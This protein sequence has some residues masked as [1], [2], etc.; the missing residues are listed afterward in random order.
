M[1]WNV[2]GVRWNGY[3]NAAIQTASE[4]GKDKARK[5]SIPDEKKDSEKRIKKSAHLLIE[6]LKNVR[7]DAGYMSLSVGNRE[8]IEKTLDDIEPAAPEVD[9][10]QQKLTTTT[11]DT[12]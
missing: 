10:N 7:H 1:I 2:C 9:P 6:I 12:W 3:W 8:Y 5:A 4:H 11:G